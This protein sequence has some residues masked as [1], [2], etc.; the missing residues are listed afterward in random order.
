MTYS[1]KGIS[2][3]VEPSKIY[4]PI[5]GHDI[6]ASNAHE[7]FNGVDDGYIFIHD[8]IQH[9]EIDIEALCYEVQ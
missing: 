4:C 2:H 9:D 7:V 5:C 8:S 1:S 3:D 6:Q